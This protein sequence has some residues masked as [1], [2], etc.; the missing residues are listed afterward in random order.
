MGP[1]LVHLAQSS[2][3]HIVNSIYTKAMNKWSDR[4]AEA[5]IEDSLSDMFHSLKKI[6]FETKLSGR[7]ISS[8]EF[9]EEIKKKSRLTKTKIKDKFFASPEELRKEAISEFQEICQKEN[10]AEEVKEEKKS[11]KVA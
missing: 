11:N 4:Q 5:T 8:E 3:R 1:D 6:V 2:V 7:S 9:A 10:K